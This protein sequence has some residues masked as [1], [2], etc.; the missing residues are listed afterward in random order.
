MLADSELRE[1]V[2]FI[3]PDPVLSV[4][5]N[6]DPTQGNSDAY[7]LRLRNLLKGVSLPEDVETIER[8]FQRE[9]D[10]TG[11]GVAL[12]SCAPQGFFRTYPL[13]VPVADLVHV[14]DRPSI[15]VLADLLDSYGGYGVVVVDKQGAR[16]FSFHL[17]ELREQEGVLGNPVKRT[18]HGGASTVTGGRGGSAGLTRHQEEVV[19]RNMKEAVGFA[20]D[21]FES[22]HVRRILIGGTDDNVA[23]FRSFLPKAWQSLVVGTFPMNMGVGHVEVLDK[24][25]QIGQAAELKREEKIIEELFT[26]AAKGDDAVIGLEDTLV[27]V[28]E[29]RVSTLVVLQGYSQPAYRCTDCRYLF[30]EMHQTCPNC[31]GEVHKIPDAVDVAVS[32]TMRQGGDVEVVHANPQLELSGKIG[33]FLRY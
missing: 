20:V 6:T 3:S 11:K 26:L 25:M 5:L 8:Y 4:Y 14:S 30:E 23:Q 19:D 17:G 13:A 15:R 16:V 28:N 31:G 7:R 9:Y 29:D 27:T 21:F 24:A 12:F 1:L 10:W 18:K 33:A 2:H 32:R 22:N